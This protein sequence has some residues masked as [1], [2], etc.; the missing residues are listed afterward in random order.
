MRLRFALPH[1]CTIIVVIIIVSAHLRVTIYTIL[2][3]ITI[4]RSKSCTLFLFR[5]QNQTLL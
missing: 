3:R 2:L 4:Q 1:A 5:Y